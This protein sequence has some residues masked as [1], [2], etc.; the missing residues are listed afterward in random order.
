M[1]QSPADSNLSA[2][3]DYIKSWDALGSMISRGRSFSA[4]E[5]HCAFLNP[6]HSSGKNAHRFANISAS[7][8][9]DYVDDGRALAVT[10]WDG[11][12]DLDLWLSNR[13]GPR[14]KFLR[15]DIV[16]DN[17]S[18]TLSLQGVASNRDAI[19]ARATVTVK[20]NGEA[21]TS[22]QTV[23]AGES[24]LSQ[25]SKTLTF[26]IANGESIGKV[27]VR[28]PG[29]VTPE[30]FSG[31][32]ADRRYQLT[33]GSGDAVLV[34]VK[35][36]SLALEPGSTPAT[37]MDEQARIVR[38]FREDMPEITYVDFEGNLRELNDDLKNGP[39]LVNLWASWC[40]PCITELVEFK[41][42]H[43]KLAASN[44]SIVAL[45]TD[46]VTEDGAKP[47]IGPAKRLV[48][49]QQFPFQV[50]AVD[51]NTV[52]LLTVVHNSAISRERPLP[53]PSSFLV[54][55][56]GKVAVIYKGPIGVDQL[57]KDVAMLGKTLE[58]AREQAFPFPAKDGQQLFELTALRFAQAFLRVDTLTTP[59]PPS[60]V[61]FIL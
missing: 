43:A 9:A 1:A 7:T 19:G 55:G 8:G 10:D 29:D 37:A 44:L 46:P 23:R 45:N 12:G 4:Y 18:L 53:L 31:I 38:Y 42:N 17:Q 36:R 28:W 22:S 50:G 24:F 49:K 60:Q 35:N 54:D 33:Q 61:T 20:T 51:A 59:A 58:K 41:E 11:D 5:R 32:E 47:D 26:G 6:G 15:N 3:S 39:T 2:N 34:P 40:G 16:D 13:T 48:K 57:S 27:E 21:R 30:V 52:R 25:S 56:Q 14:V